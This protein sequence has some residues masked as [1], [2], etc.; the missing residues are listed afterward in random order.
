MN[1]RLIWIE[2]DIV[3]V[4][5]SEIMIELITIYLNGMIDCK[6]SKMYL[7]LLMI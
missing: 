7:S 4:R 1:L 2:N 6:N 5:S 3:Y